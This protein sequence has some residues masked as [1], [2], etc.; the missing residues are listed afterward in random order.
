[1][2]KQIE[3]IINKFDGGMVND[4]RDPATNT[5]QVVSNFDVLTDV[6]RMLPYRSSE[7]GDS[8]PTTSQKQNFLV[9][10]WGPSSVY[11]LFSLGVVSGTGR[12]EVLM[13]DVT[14]GGSTDLGDGGWG[15]PANNQSA[16]GATS[17]NLFVYYKNKTTTGGRN[18]IFGAKPAVGIWAFTPDDSTAFNE[19]AY[20]LVHTNSAQGLVHS[21]DDILYIP[22]DNK[23]HKK[24][25]GTTA[26]DNWSEAL[27]LPIDLYITSIC[28]YG[29]YLAIAMAPLNG[30][31]NSR[32]FIWDR[33]SSLTTLA[34]TIDW[35]TEKLQVIETVDGVLVGVALSG[36]NSTRFGDRIVF[37]YLSGS[38][39]VKFQE[40]IAGNTLTNLPIAKQKANNRLYFMMNVSINGA[41]R[42]GVWSV[43]RNTPSSPFSIVHERTQNNDTAMVDGVLRNFFLLGDFMFISYQS[44]A[45]FA[46]SKTNDTATHTATSIYESKIFNDGDNSLTKKLI[47]VTVMT[48]YLPTAGQV[49]LKYKLDQETTY[50]TIFTNTTDNSISHSAVNIES[51]GITLP[52][53]KE[54]SFR[55]ES[56]GNAVITG[57]SY[58]S[59]V[60]GKRVY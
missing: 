19:S 49:V 4:P 17:F 36:G 32:V 52:E 8:A 45:A 30:I 41:T 9:A 35:G 22:L 34:D 13:K 1:M 27:V 23:I 26:S 38:N 5:C 2:G 7:S 42:E 57:F 53:Y 14:T 29:N 31:G 12:A 40:F 3:T 46:L 60:I 43:G 25:G 15:T 56:T 18:F 58:K 20:A 59:E 6:H 50:T 28:E 55:I 10:L 21:K 39:A 51:T 33:D 47:G 44:N 24:N 54:I 11:R 48:E 37:R 16:S